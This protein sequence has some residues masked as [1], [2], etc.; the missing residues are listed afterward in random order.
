MVIFVKKTLKKMENKFLNDKSLYSFISIIYIL[1]LIYVLF[2]IDPHSGQDAP[3]FSADAISIIRNGPFSSLEYAPWW[4]V[5]YSWF[6]AFWW[7]IFGIDSRFL[8]VVQTSLLLLAQILAIKLVRRLFDVK[9]SQVFGY[10][11]MINLAMFSSSGQLM[12][13]VPLGSFLI[14]GAFNLVSLL[15]NEVWN[16]KAAI[17]S[18]VCFGLAILM[19]PSALAP[20]LILLLVATYGNRITKKLVVQV[21]MTLTL[22]F[23]GVFSQMARNYYAGDGWGLSTTTF[24][25]AQLGGWGTNN[26]NQAVKCEQIGSLLSGKRNQNRWDNP[27]RQICLYLVTFKSPIKILQITRFNT[28]RYWSPFVGIL[29]GGGTWYHG[30]DWRRV[31]TPWYQWWQGWARIADTAVGYLWIISHLTLAMLGVF[32]IN[33]RRLVGSPQNR[34][35]IL[36]L[37]LPVLSTYL[38]SLLTLGDTRHRMPTMIFYEIFV[39]FGL[40]YIVRK[41]NNISA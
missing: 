1:R 17:L 16:F 34:K 7:R 12:Y 33:R 11:I 35:T 5:G 37:L 14:L 40:V 31:V 9:T 39:T 15:K 29:K 24:S 19:H 23:T 38:V 3:S 30:L 25:N 8:G 4:P 13:E 27:K 10:L 26:Q 20:A 6:V 41:I 2:V 36:F 18:G 28:Q 32:E 21:L 22:L